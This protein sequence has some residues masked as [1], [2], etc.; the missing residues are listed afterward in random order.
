MSRSVGVVLHSDRSLVAELF[1]QLSNQLSKHGI[2]SLEITTENFS[3]LANCEILVVLGGD[4][5]ILK[6][7]ELSHGYDI[8]IL[9]INLGRVGFLAEAEVTDVNSAVE[10]IV[11]KTW[12]TELRTMLDVKVVR[13]GVSVF[14]SYAINDASIEKVSTELMTE[15]RVSVDDTVLMAFSGDG[16]IV[17]TP[18]GSTAYAFSAGG[19]VLWP[20]TKAIITVPIAAHALFARPLVFNPTSK[21][22]SEILSDAASLNLDGRRKFELQNGD[23]VR[24]TG[25]AKDLHFARIHST[26]FAERLVKKFRLPT[27]S[28]RETDNA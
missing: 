23:L 9:G 25:S 19:P 27:T 24:V 5:T 4:G 12:E 2:T 6:A 14:E 15:L 18:T 17:A 8:P 11:N 1:G 28:W 26:S 13:N 7:V 22:Q 16:L 10:T 3:E 21:L 20:N